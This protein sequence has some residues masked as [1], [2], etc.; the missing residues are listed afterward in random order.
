MM[1]DPKQVP[2]WDQ[3]KFD[4]LKRSAEAMKQVRKEIS[5]AKREAIER[6][7]AEAAGSE[8]EKSQNLKAVLC[9]DLNEKI[10]ENQPLSD[11]EQEEVDEQILG[12]DTT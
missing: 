1:A 6:Q 4:N 9:F 11:S 7:E 3:S 10:K 12:K 8:E 5:K 2:H